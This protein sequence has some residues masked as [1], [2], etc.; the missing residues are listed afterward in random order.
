MRSGAE[1]WGV[2]YSGDTRPCASV[3]SLG[4]NLG[5]RCLILIREATFDDSEEMA[6]EA[7]VCAQG[8]ACSLTHARLWF[9]EIETVH[10]VLSDCVPLTKCV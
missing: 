4:S 7:K 5:C 2:V 3:A 10:V 6:I 1:G 9:C 8:N